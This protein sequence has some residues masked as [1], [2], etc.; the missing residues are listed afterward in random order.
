MFRAY[1]VRHYY[2]DKSI[3]PFD[4]NDKILLKNVIR[5]IDVPDLNDGSNDHT[6]C[7]KH[8]WNVTPTTCQ[9][10][11]NFGPGLHFR[12]ECRFGCPG[13]IERFNKD[14]KDFTELDFVVETIEI[15]ML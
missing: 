5:G 9:N 10:C 8:C 12:D 15:N 1:N 7:K 6:G 13:L 3:F 11:I 2:V 4:F 14:P